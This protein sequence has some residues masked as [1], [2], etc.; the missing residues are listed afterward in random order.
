[1]IDPAANW[2]EGETTEGQRCL[3]DAVVDG[4][5]VT[6]WRERESRKPPPHPSENWCTAATNSGSRCLRDAHTDGLCVTHWRE[7]NKDR[8]RKKRYVQ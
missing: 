4:L 5:C 1:M 6:H 7:A 3:K 2:C 8:P